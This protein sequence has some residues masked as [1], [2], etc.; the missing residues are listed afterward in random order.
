ME[1]AGYA[2]VRAIAGAG[3]SAKRLLEEIGRRD[4]LREGNCLVS[5][6][7]FGVDQ[8]GFV[9]QI[10]AEEGAVEVRAALEQEADHVALGED[11]EDGRKA[12]TSGVIGNGDDFGAVVF[13]CG[14]PGAGRGCAAEDQEI[15][16]SGTDELRE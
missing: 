6:L 3:N 16:R 7:S 12:E 8:D 11:S 10:L 14:E 4:A 5:Q 9:D 13:E 1:V 2:G 15:I